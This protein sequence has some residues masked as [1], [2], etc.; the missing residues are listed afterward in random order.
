MPIVRV[1]VIKKKQVIKHPIPAGPGVQNIHDADDL[2]SGRLRLLDLGVVGATAVVA[3][4]AVRPAPTGT[5]FLL[6][7]DPPPNDAVNVHF[8]QGGTLQKHV[9]ACIRA[10]DF[11]CSNS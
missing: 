11:S 10:S 2:V 6:G 3:V 7:D 4:C 9:T 8:L 1:T 5:R